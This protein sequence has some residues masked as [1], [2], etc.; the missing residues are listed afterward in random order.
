MSGTAAFELGDQLMPFIHRASDFWKMIPLVL[1][2]L[3]AE[4]IGRSG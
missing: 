2:D 4:H 3:G 1:P